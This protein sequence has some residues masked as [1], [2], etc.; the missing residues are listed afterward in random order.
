MTIVDTL[1]PHNQRRYH[2]QEKKKQSL[3]ISIIDHKQRSVSPIIVDFFPLSLDR[4]ISRSK[5]LLYTQQVVADFILVYTQIRADD[6]HLPRRRTAA[7]QVF[8][9][10]GT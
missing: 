8:L 2:Q 10:V 7:R 1:E 5:Q 4:S 3:S 9:F 6:E